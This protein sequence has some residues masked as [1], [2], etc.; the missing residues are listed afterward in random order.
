MLGL[1]S[2]FP[3]SN[4][5]ILL[6]HIPLL[7]QIFKSARNNKDAHMCSVPSCFCVI[8]DA[9]LPSPNTE[10]NVSNKTKNKQ[11]YKQICKQRG[12]FPE[13]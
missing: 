8:C 12:F 5:N 3:E 9:G 4:I 13:C 11:A 1:I 7:T 6:L 2:T 10:K